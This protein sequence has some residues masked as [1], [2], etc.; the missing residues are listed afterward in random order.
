[1]HDD[2]Y[3]TKR[4]ERDSVD[5]ITPLS[6]NKIVAP[7]A[8][9]SFFIISCV[10][11]LSAGVIKES[12]GDLRGL[13]ALCHCPLARGIEKYAKKKRDDGTKARRQG[14]PSLEKT[15]RGVYYRVAERIWIF[16]QLASWPLIR[17]D[18]VEG[19]LLLRNC[20]GISL[21]NAC[22]LIS[23]VFAPLPLPYRWLCRARCVK[24][25]ARDPLLKRYAATASTRLAYPV[26]A[27]DARKERERERETPS[28]A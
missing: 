5:N 14:I 11:V 26:C 17:H 13:A 24:R 8:P 21:A 16:F 3:T 9:H 15:E 4:I 6:S 23:R 1:M 25:L 10:K 27:S 22:V 2:V 28:L 18:R 12:S 20:G 7:R 19:S